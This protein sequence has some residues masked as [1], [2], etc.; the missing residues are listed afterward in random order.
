MG[1]EPLIRDATA[2]DVGELREVR[3]RASLSNEGDR[4]YLDAHPEVLEYELI[5]GARTRV[6]EIDGRVVGFATVLP[7][8]ELEDLFTDPAFMRR[9]I[10]TALVR[11]AGAPLT[12][13]ANP[14][15]LAFYE[16]VG[17]VTEGWDDT[18]GGPGHRMRLV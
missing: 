6:A 11:D 3:R 15:A 14:H 8:R 12:V 13:T 17:F 18:P 10:A 5:P 2:A 9:G 1:T 4:A 16:R 7:D